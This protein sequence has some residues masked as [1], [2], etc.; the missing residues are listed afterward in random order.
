MKYFFFLLLI[1]FALSTGA[2]NLVPNPSFEDTVYCPIEIDSID[3]CADW[4]SGWQPLSTPNYFNSCSSNPDV[5]PPNVIW[6]YQ[7]PHS[8]NAYCFVATYATYSANV[9]ETIQ[10]EL[11]QGL[12][13]GQRYFVSFYASFPGLGADQIAT[14]K[15]GAL[16][17]TYSFTP[18]NFVTPHNFSQVYTD[19][20][21]LDTINWFHIRGS[22]IADSAYQFI[23][24]GNFFDDAH[25][26]TLTLPGGF[27]IGSGYFIDDVCVSMD[28]SLCYRPTSTFESIV[29]FKTDVF[30]NPA[31]QYFYV[32]EQPAK[33][34]VLIYD[35]FGNLVFRSN[36][37]IA[38]EL[39]ID[40]STWMDGIYLLE[41]NSS[42]LRKIQIIH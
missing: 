6:G 2:Q 19:S 21:I 20:I 23:T 33:G 40:C 39:K 35:L 30:P 36:H 38:T 10:A 8:G 37:S 14:N 32:V 29:D 41:I 34:A 27:R 16:F 22:F 17:T 25:T 11:T 12:I 7:T 1:Y 28:S 24:I 42:S 9:R 3:A 13:I 26:D 4:H 15:L 31:S 18:V 5:S